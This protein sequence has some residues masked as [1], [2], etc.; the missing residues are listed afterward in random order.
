MKVIM[1]KR[2]DLILRTILK[3]QSIHGTLVQ[4]RETYGNSEERQRGKEEV[5]S[6]TMDL[7]KLM[8]D[9]SQF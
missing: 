1:K 3:L 4:I 7:E 6:R 9:F 8:R 5:E 2:M